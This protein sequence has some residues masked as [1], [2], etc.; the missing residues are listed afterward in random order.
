MRWITVNLLF[1]W[2]VSAIVFYG[3]VLN[4]GSLAGVFHLRHFI[5]N[6]LSSEV[7][8]FFRIHL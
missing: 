4:V 2:F 6:I 1:L 7:V 8:I 3:L 5:Q